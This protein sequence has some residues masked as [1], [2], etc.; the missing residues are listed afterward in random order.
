MILW[1]LWRDNI[2]NHNTA[3]TMTDPVRQRKTLYGLP[4]SPLS[5]IDK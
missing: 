4:A 5:R 1:I 2:M 3:G